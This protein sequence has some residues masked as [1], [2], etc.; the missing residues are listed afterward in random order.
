M[1]DNIR[2]EYTNQDTGETITISKV[3]INEV[4]SHGSTAVE[5]LKSLHSI[6]DMIENAIFIDEIPNTKGNDKYDSYRYYVCGLKIDG[7]DYTAKIV[8]GVKGGNKYYDHRLT[9]IEK[10]ALIDRLNG[11]SNSV[12]EDQS[13]NA[14]GKD[15]KLSSLLQANASKVVDENGEPLVV[16]HGA[17][18]NEQFHAFYNGNNFFIDNKRVAQM[19][20]D[21]CAYRLIV[22]GET[23]V[24]SKKEAREIASSIE[25]Y[26][27]N[28]ILE[29]FN[30]GIDN[31]LEDIT[32]ID[33]LNQLIG[34]GGIQN[35][36]DTFDG[37]KKISIKPAANQLFEVF[38]NIRNPQVI[39]FGGEVWEVGDDAT[40]TP[41]L[42]YDGVIA[43]NII[44]GGA[45]AEIDGEEPP[46]ATDYV[47]RN[48]NQIKS[49]TD[50]N[51]SFSDGSDDIRFHVAPLTAGGGAAAIERVADAF[52]KVLEG[53]GT[54]GRLTKMVE[55]AQNGYILLHKMFTHLNEA[56]VKKGLKPLSVAQDMETVAAGVRRGGGCS[57]R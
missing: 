53:K 37:A 5:H 29:L 9:E 25:P 8:V 1:L 55:E 3:G 28:D 15:T 24:L 35:G 26:Y 49:A 21:E 43:K 7:I 11:L 18:T 51:G 10:G 44:E 13:T 34:S 57:G 4:T 36:I 52:L 12:A 45:T 40:L 20:A 47:V 30:Q 48:P 23:Y 16:W 32:T 33:N 19:F 17:R 41:Q 42:P 6:P 50:N 22:D 27:P 46:P 31:I 2:G 56:R 14:V 39:D 38:L 54:H